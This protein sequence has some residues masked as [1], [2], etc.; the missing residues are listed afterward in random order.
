MSDQHFYENLPAFDEFSRITDSD[1]YRPL[2]K[3]WYVA[4]ADVVGSTAAIASGRYKHVNVVGA[5]IKDPHTG[6]R[7]RV[8]GGHVRVVDRFNGL[9]CR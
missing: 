3:D 2:P 1:H 6:L 8:E 7:Y 4:I 5:C 9:E